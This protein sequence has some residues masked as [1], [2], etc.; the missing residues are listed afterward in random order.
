MSFTGDGE[1]HC[2]AVHLD[3]L[4][5]GGPRDT[6]RWAARLVFAISLIGSALAPQ[7]HSAP[8]GSQAREEPAVAT[9]P[10][11]REQRADSQP[12]VESI[13]RVVIPIPGSALDLELVRVDL[14][15]DRPLWMSRSEITWD[16]LDAFVYAFDLEDDEATEVDGITRPSKPYISMDRGFGKS[17]FPAISVNHRLATE[18]CQWLS[19]RSGRTLRLPT[20]DE[21]RRACERSGIDAA[22]L[23]DFAWCAEN[24]GQKTH[25]VRSRQADR[26][27]LHDLFGNA[28]EWVDAGDGAFRVV[29][30]SFRDSAATMSCAMALERDPAWNASDPQIPKSIWWLADGGFVGFRVVVE[31]PSRQPS[32]SLPS[33]TPPTEEPAAPTPRPVPATEPRP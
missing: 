28:A 24:A 12:S 29:G 30:G 7:L 10:V 9:P 4:H 22:S 15:L 27:G 1:D 32:E 13:E 8:E 23:P 16:M 33:T 6:R 2:Q 18:F 20:L 5:G 17:G 21:W 25:P 3:G 19:A 11:P 14:G 31:E 26:L